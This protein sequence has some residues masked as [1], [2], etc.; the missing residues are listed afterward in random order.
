MNAIID[1]IRREPAV[2]FTLVAAALGLGAAFGLD[3]SKEQTGAVMAF[4]TAVVGFIVRSQ[5]TPTVSVGAAEADN[6]KGAELVAG[7]ASEV[8]DE[9]P[10]DVVP[11]YGDPDESFDIT[12]KDPPARF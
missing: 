5:V 9:T 3:L 6:E 10:V 12:P 1:K 7:P 2:F 11:T 4:V 8:P